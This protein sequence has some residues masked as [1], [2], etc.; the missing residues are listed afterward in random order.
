M[1]ALK[2]SQTLTIMCEDAGVF[3]N[4]LRIAGSFGLYAQPL[5]RTPMLKASCPDLRMAVL[6]NADGSIDGETVSR[7]RNDIEDEYGFN[8]AL[9]HA[10][11]DGRNAV[12]VM[13]ISPLLR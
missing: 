3:A 1:T 11:E 6:E 7:F 4:V 9:L 13:E 8:C 10:V 5:Q 2:S 12:A